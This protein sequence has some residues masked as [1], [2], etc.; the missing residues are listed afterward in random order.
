MSLDV[1]DL[2]PDFTLP[3]DQGDAITLSQQHGQ[4]VVLYFYPKADT[5]GC[6]KQALLLRD[7]FAEF[8][9]TDAVI[10]GVSKD[11]VKK[12]ATFKTKHD[13]PFTLVS[14]ADNTACADYG[15]WVKKSMYGRDYMGIERSTFLINP[16]GIIAKI[17][18]KVKIPGHVDQ[19]L[20][21]TRSI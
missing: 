4:T 16:Q 9:A 11:P 15:V 12:L 18:R 20:E 17:W 8:T 10:I 3:T 19:L 5:S 7:S 21:A 14:D 13:L 6:T 2:A 1:G